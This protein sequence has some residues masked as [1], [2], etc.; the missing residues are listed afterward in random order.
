MVAETQKVLISSRI[1]WSDSAGRLRIRYD[2]GT[3]TVESGH[4]KGP[5]ERVQVCPEAMER[6]IS[7]WPRLREEALKGVKTT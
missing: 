7:E 3:Y 4:A 5:I 2:C 1:I 6:L